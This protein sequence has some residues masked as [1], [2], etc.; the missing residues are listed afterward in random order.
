MSLTQKYYDCFKSSVEK[1]FVP[2]NCVVPVSGGLDSTLIVKAICDLGLKNSCAFLSYGDNEYIKQVE[3]TYGISSRRFDVKID[4]FENYLYEIVE[5]WEEPYY[6]VSIGYFLYKEIEKMG[7]RVSLSGL[8]PDELCGGYTYY[9]TDKYPRGIMQEISAKK[10]SEKLI[11]D[12]HLLMFHHLR[13]NDK[14]GLRFNVEGRYPF[15]DKYLQEYNKDCFGKSLIKNILE[16][17]LGKKFINRKKDG[18]KL[19]WIE[20]DIIWKHVNSLKLKGFNVNPKNIKQ[21]MFFCQFNIWLE[22]FN[23]N[24]KNIVFKNNIFKAIKG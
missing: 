16:N 7:I 11:R 1:R 15:L 23:I 8:G 12:N 9:N 17:D 4:N 14:L 19:N 5:I 22:I 18:F 21:A 3:N 10:N 13:K 24:H 6:W 20:Q 2:N